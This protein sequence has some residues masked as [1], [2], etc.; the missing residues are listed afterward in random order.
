MERNH[1]SL[2]ASWIGNLIDQLIDKSKVQLN[3]PNRNCI[4]DTTKNIGEFL[5]YPVHLGEKANRKY[6]VICYKNFQKQQ[7]TYFKCS[8]CGVGLCV[9]KECFKMYHTENH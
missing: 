2:H 1:D 7:R 9:D 8:D 3:Q 4:D 6:C 5:H